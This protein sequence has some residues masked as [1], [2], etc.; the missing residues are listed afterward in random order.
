MA[1]NQLFVCRPTDSAFLRAQ[2]D[3]ANQGAGSKTVV[4]EAPLGGGKR[5]VVGDMVRHLL[6]DVGAEASKELIVVR[7]AFSDE[8]DGLRCMLNLYAALYGAIFREDTLK[9]KAEAA[10]NAQL[11]EQN[12][13]VQQWYQA[14]IE[15]L[16]KG[17]P[18]AGEKTFQLTIPRDNPMAGFAEIVGALAKKLPIILEIQNV[19]NSHSVSSFALIEALMAQ[20]ESKLLVILGTE[21]ATDAALSWMPGPWLDLL[22]RRKDDLARLTLAPWGADEVSAYLASREISAAAP[23]RIAEIAHGRPAYVAE[24]VD[25]LKDSDRLGDDLEGQTLAS[26]A[27]RAPDEDE[28][29]E[30]EG[31]A[32]DGRKFATAE[33]ADRIL[34]VAA[35]LGLSFPSG[36]VADMA[37]YERDSVD[38][39]FDA[40]PELLAE[41]QFSKPLGTWV[42]QFKKAIWRQA[43]L[44]LHTSDQDKVVGQR[45][46][47]FMERFLVPRGYEFMVKTIR[48]FGE[49]GAGDR[50]N[51]MRG[52]ALSAD[53]PD[54][55]AMTLDL[56][57]SNPNIAWPDNM[58]RATYSNLLDRMVQGGDVEQAEALHQEVLKWSMDRG[59]KAM[60]A[61]VRFAGSRLDFR[62]QDLYRGRDRAREA[63]TLFSALGDKLKVAELHN[64][65]ALIEFSDSSINASLDHL[66]RALEEAN[67]PPIQANV[68][69]IR[70]LISQRAN[71]AQE[72][73]EHF[74]KANELA[75][76]I[77]M[78]PLALE[79]G[80]KYGEALFVLRDYSRAADVLLRVAQIAASLQNQVRERAAVA[81]LTQVHG[82]LRNHEA[83]LQSASRTLQ[84]TQELK[85]E[86]A[87]AVDIY[88][89]GY[90]NLLLGRPTEAVSLFKKARERVSA[91]DPRFL[92]ELT[93]HLGSASKQVGERASAITALK[94]A[95]S[96]S[97][98]TKEYRR[99]V[100]SC[101]MLAELEATG[102]NK[103]AAAKYL[104]E[105]LQAADAGKLNEE[106]KGIL[107]R[108]K[109]LG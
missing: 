35:L 69:F 57:R 47:L 48:M 75:G 1:E 92:R 89:V 36:L 21:M 23:G 7:A 71:K 95:L 73:A 51:M 94:E 98:Q 13:R 106:R 81:L 67:V 56:L 70:G 39:L 28:L 45:V 100:Q 26:L 55:W 83:A 50:A 46:A 60:E 27:P 88:H 32:K 72:A 4:L 86:Q 96:H 54:I 31:T 38:D 37:G 33:D 65:L 80:F 20:K 14:F 62:R 49:N 78:A 107:R 61:W 87:M 6:E 84:L 90:Y 22:D 79:S 2:F 59:D 93:F 16:K 53:R 108:I 68:E 19:H 8:E 91:D 42:Y 24:L 58:R 3:A 97:R 41:M 29:E 64:H 43:M 52:A 44:D 82:Q 85:F 101:E 40:L 66:R 103:T 74:K 5:A 102:G 99:A 30:N 25:F 9:F 77:G 34:Y 18:P 17:A 104:D 76:N 10:L 109:D 63:L 105:A 12:R 15:G 11:T